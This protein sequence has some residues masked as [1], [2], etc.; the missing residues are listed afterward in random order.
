VSPRVH[1]GGFSKTGRFSSSA[2]ANSPGPV[3]LVPSLMDTQH[4][5]SHVYRQD[6]GPAVSRVSTAN[7]SPTRTSVRSRSAWLMGST[8]DDI[9]H[10]KDIADTKGPASYLPSYDLVRDNPPR[11]VFQHT[12]RFGPATTPG[13]E[14]RN[15][16]MHSPGPKYLP[17]LST[18]EL[19][20]A[21]P[22]SYSFRSQHKLADRSQFVSGQIRDG[23]Y[24]SADCATRNSFSQGSGQPEKGEALTMS[25]APRPVWGRADRFRAPPEMIGLARR[26]GKVDKY[27]VHS[28]GPAY[29]PRNHEIQPPQR[30]AVV[31]KGKW[32]P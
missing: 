3:Y 28:P 12:K 17:R 13:T 5:H 2:K 16:C 29:Y 10:Y 22:P 31:A 6:V 4:V 18:A 24:Y 26:P 23:Y 14:S 15:L 25:T 11:P 32:V 8:V 1:G 20:S 30:I 21:T 27:G 7:A 9:A 19:R